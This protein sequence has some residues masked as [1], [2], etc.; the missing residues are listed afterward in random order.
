MFGGI[1][2][3]LNASVRSQRTSI[4]K[5]QGTLTISDYLGAQR[6]HYRPKPWLAVVLIV[7]CAASFWYAYSWRDWV[8]ALLPVYFAA[9]FLV[10][11][12]LKARRTFR[13][14]KA[15]ADPMT[16]EVRDDG[17]FLSNAYSNGLLPWGH[18]Y[19]WKHSARLVLIYRASNLMHI[20][21]SRFFQSTSDYEAFLQILRSK[22]SAAT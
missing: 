18:I 2:P 20:I 12:P 10:Y 1:A 4:M 5:A 15:L 22:T 17:I 11:I 21:P 14:N 13:Q 19:K 7:L 16:V 6:L 8:M 9:V 3:P